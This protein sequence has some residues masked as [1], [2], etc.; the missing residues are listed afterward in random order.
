MKGTKPEIIL[1]LLIILML[2]SMVPPIL[3]I[4]MKIH[5]GDSI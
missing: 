2:I 1:Q 3:K 5:W 4:I